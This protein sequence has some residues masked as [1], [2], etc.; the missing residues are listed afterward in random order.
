MTR[1]TVIFFPPAG[2]NH[3]PEDFIDRIQ[4]VAEAARIMQH[5]NAIS[6]LSE[7]RPHERPGVK[8]FKKIYQLTCGNHR[9]YFDTDE[10]RL[11]VVLY[12]CR[13][14]SNETKKKDLDQALR[15]LANYYRSK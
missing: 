3:S 6:K 9:L 14:R 13:K 8:R 7:L 10:G 1:W 2:E 12:A 4:P 5:L 11:I 15:N